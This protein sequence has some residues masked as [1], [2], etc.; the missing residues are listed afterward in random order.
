[1]SQLEEP[2]TNLQDRVSERLTKERV[3]LE[4]RRA[5]RPFA[6]WL[7]LLAGAAVALVLLL[8]KL[9]LPAPWS[10]QYDFSVAVTNADAVAPNDQVR[11]AGVQVGR[12][13][14]VAL[15]ADRPLI[16][17]SLDP[18]YAPLYRDAR[19]E[20]RPNT[21]LQDMYLDIVSRGTRPAGRVSDG[22]T[23]AASQ[24]G[25]PVQIGQVLD[26]FDAAVR[27][28][29]TASINALGAGLGDHGVQLRDALVELAPFLQEARELN[30]QLANRRIET[31][32]LVHNFSLLSTELAGRTGQLRGLVAAGAV[33]LQGLNS[34]A[35]PLG[36]LIDQLPPTLAELP[37]SFSTLRGAA[38]RLDPA[39]TAL[40]PAAHALAPAMVALKRVSPT[41]N[42]ALAGLDHALPALTGLVRSATPLAG[43]LQQAFD[44]LRPQVPELFHATTRLLPCEL[45]V[46]KFAQWTLSVSKLSSAQ[47][48][49]Q[50]GVALIS[51]QTE[52]DLIAGAKSP[53]V[54]RRA[55]T[56]TGQGAGG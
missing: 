2:P 28:R 47:G 39:A 50:R 13:T 29:V 24:T 42:A 3:G 32:R 45:A 31:E 37:K 52:G 4:L 30:L 16:S 5:R 55:P 34:E 26:I 6:Q 48:D 43:H 41:A 22:G 54:L 46:S 53:T 8:I 27:P 56:C 23:L 36:Q 17:V 25:T 49:L 15:R 38:V 14:H 33:T 51:P 1:V 44:R 10:S 7:L 19:V 40:L 35:V 20:L 21:P 18:Q 12:V 11:I 9:H